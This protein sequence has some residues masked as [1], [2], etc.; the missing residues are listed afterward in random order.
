M[1]DTKILI[2]NNNPLW[3]QIFQAVSTSGNEHHET[4]I[5]TFFKNVAVS[6]SVGRGKVLRSMATGCHHR[7]SRWFLECLVYQIHELYRVLGDGNSLGDRFFTSGIPLVE[8]STIPLATSHFK[9]R[10]KGKIIAPELKAIAKIE[11]QI[12]SGLVSQSFL[13]TLG[14]FTKDLRQTSPEVSQRKS[15]NSNR[16]AK[17]PLRS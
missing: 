16:L 1:Y 10:I 7:R 15:I 14:Y 5:E 8:D 2:C 4:F 13:A 6:W 11:N 17:A 9:E 3:N 12:R